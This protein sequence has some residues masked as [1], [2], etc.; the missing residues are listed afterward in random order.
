MSPLTVGITNLV[1]FDR[2]SVNRLH[3][4]KISVCIIFDKRVLYVGCKNY[5]HSGVQDTDDWKEFNWWWLNIKYE[6]GEVRSDIW[7]LSNLWGDFQM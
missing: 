5:S 4:P 1:V 6:E 2:Q 3:F 7:N